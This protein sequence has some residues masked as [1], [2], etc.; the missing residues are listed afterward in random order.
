MTP[1]IVQN[2]D[3]VT[4]ADT[5]CGTMLALDNGTIAFFP[6]L[7]LGFGPNASVEMAMLDASL[8]QRG[9]K[10]CAVQYGRTAREGYVSRL[11][12]PT[13]EKPGPTVQPPSGGTRLARC[14]EQ[15][16]ALA[17]VAAAFQAG[18]LSTLLTPEARA[19][20]AR[21]QA[22]AGK[23]AAKAAVDAKEFAHANWPKAAFAI[24]IDET[25]HGLVLQFNYNAAVVKAVK[26]SKALWSPFR[27]TWTLPWEHEVAFGKRLMKIAK[28]LGKV[29]DDKSVPLAEQARQREAEMLEEE[30]ALP[31]VGKVGTLAIGLRYDPYAPHGHQHIYTLRFPYHTSMIG[32]V[33]GVPGARFNKG[34]GHWEIPLVARNSLMHKMQFIRSYVLACEGSAPAAGKEVQEF[35]AERVLATSAA[36]ES[37]R[38]TRDARNDASQR[39]SATREG[40]WHVY[41]FA[42]RDASGLPTGLYQDGEKWNVVVE[43]SR[44]SYVEDASSLGGDM[45]REYKF[46]L[47]VRAA[48]QQEVE[49]ALAQR[50][51][52][53]AM[54]KEAKAR[55]AAFE[56]LDKAFRHGDHPERVDLPQGV[57][58]TPRGYLMNVNGRTVWMTN[59]GA[60]F[61]IDRVL[62]KVWHVQENG[63][64][65][66]NW[67]R[68]NYCSSIASCL[69]LNG[70][71]KVVAFLEAARAPLS[72]PT[73]ALMAD[74]VGTWAT[75]GQQ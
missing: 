53:A 29:S 32:L 17:E 28:T 50:A 41:R 1:T 68:N 39:A 20:E 44:G 64:D 13:E 62:G 58:S 51:Q 73:P 71:D 69:S 24:C 4:S 9:L 37:Q 22:K 10:W 45:F 55:G 30:R 26:A 33:R 48:T 11:E 34:V 7:P 57:Q 63:S 27:K 14:N 38:K 66:D 65:G 5:S 54:H 75:T 8:A 46:R 36:R 18:D 15:L 70:A 74:D 56:L 40:S 2:F 61:V 19:V 35:A 67:S 49:Q 42:E 31:L 59:G 25:A 3:G 6:N 16:A 72:S 23:K 52:A 43:R 12:K 21:E 60:R 47:T